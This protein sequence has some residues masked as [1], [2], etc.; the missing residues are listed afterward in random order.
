MNNSWL[1]KRQHIFIRDLTYDFISTKETFNKIIKEHKKTSTISL[2]T[3][4]EWIGSEKDKHQLWHLKDISHRLFRD[5]NEK[6]NLYENLF[7]WT[8]G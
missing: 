1:E 4:E 6:N 2:K 8:I 7:D 5:S 3:M